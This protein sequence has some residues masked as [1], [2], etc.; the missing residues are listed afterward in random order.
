MSIQPLVKSLAEASPDGWN[1]DL[2]GQVTWRTFFSA[3]LSPTEALTLG[4]AELAEGQ[5]L[6]YHRHLPPEIYYILS[7]QAIV[8]IDGNDNSV[9]ANTAVFI[10]GNALHGIKNAGQEIV[11]FIYAFAV[12]SFESVVYDFA[13]PPLAESDPIRTEV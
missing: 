9:S 12:D 1:D 4:F 2:H 6:K 13:V 10:P 7:G 8:H 3:G 11:K 5:E